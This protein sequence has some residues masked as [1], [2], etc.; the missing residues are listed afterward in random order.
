MKKCHKSNN[1]TL[2]FNETLNTN[3]PAEAG[4]KLK[5]PLVLNAKGFLF[6][7]APAGREV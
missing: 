4:R 3:F 2:S 1:P 7:P 5:T 6:L